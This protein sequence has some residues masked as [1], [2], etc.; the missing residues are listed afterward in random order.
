[1]TTFKQNTSEKLEHK[2]IRDKCKVVQTSQRAFLSSESCFILISLSDFIK[3][4]L[5][6]K[7]FCFPGP[8]SISLQSFLLRMKKKCSLDSTCSEDSMYEHGPGP[9]I[10]LHRDDFLIYNKKVSCLQIIFKQLPFIKIENSF[11]LVTKFVEPLFCC[12]MWQLWLSKHLKGRFGANRPVLF[13]PYCEI[14]FSQWGRQPYSGR[15]L[16][17]LLNWTC[18][19][20]DAAQGGEFPSFLK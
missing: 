16:P 15:R 13:C 3:F 10:L 11:L 20:E 18:S 4:R 1:M 8:I 9:E 19:K 7:C 6:R 2:I 5:C 14:F 12:N 17:T